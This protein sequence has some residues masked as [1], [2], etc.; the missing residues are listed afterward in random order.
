M[1]NIKNHYFCD[2]YPE[3]AQEINERGTE[4]LAESITQDQCLIYASVETVYGNEATRSLIPCTEDTLRS[5]ISLFAKTKMNDENIVLKSNGV[6]N[7]I[8]LF[9]CLIYACQLKFRLCHDHNEQWSYTVEPK[10]SDITNLGNT[11]DSAP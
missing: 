2:R 6:V 4:I 11:V 3:I 5:P 8:Q 1:I 9:C 10:L 7:F